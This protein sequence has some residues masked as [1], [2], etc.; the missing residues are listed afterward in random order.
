M[1]LQNSEM[2]K[3]VSKTFLWMF[4]GLLITASLSYY[5]YDSGFSYKLLINGYFNILLI[6][7]LAMVLLFTFLFRKLSLTGVTLLFLGYSILNG[8]TLSTIFYAF[9]IESIYMT[10]IGAALIFGALGLIGSRTNIDL[11]KV[12]TICMGTLIVG[13]IMSIVNIFMGSSTMD[14][15]INW[16]I[17]IAFF[18]I[19]AYDM[20]KLKRY[21]YSGVYGDKLHIYFALEL[22]LDFI[23]IFLRLL[24]LFGNKK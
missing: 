1:N 3:V 10:F 24:S 13:V 8:I 2:N 6:V 22:Y 23:N 14:L 7:E 9:S 20:Q 5:C 11:T 15:V 17:L 12:G 4:I 18:G 16:V 19:T 21:A